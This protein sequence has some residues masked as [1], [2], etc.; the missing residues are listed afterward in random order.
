MKFTPVLTVSGI[1]ILLFIVAVS[2]TMMI[3]MSDTGKDHSQAREH[4][5]VIDEDYNLERID[6]IHYAK[7]TGS[8]GKPA[9]SPTCYKLMGI[10]WKSLPVRY[11][12]NPTNGDG[13]TES[14]V[15]AAIAAGAETWDDN[16]NTEL[17][18]DYD[19]Y[20]I[21]YDA[22]YGEQDFVNVIA[23]GTEDADGKELSENVIA[24]TTFWWNP[25]GRQIVEFGM[26][27]ND[28]WTW[29]DADTGVFMDVQN[30]AA[31][32]MGHAVGLDDLYTSSC[33][34]VTMFGYSEEGELTKRTLEQPDI[35]GLQKIYGI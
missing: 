32:E 23:F 16:T 15:S 17:F 7:P 24:I 27:F 31:H 33:S 13:L 14:F 4:S 25:R 20:T 34:A 35:I 8:P 21:D 19:S 11:T 30:I 12:I 3:P 22:K 29:G 28:K 18:Y 1:V 5:P 26:I 2:G 9:K 6:F 10:S